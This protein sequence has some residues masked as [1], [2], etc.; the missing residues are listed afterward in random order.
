MIKPSPFIFS[1]CI[2]GE[3]WVWQHVHVWQWLPCSPARRSRPRYDLPSHTSHFFLVLYSSLCTFQCLGCSSNTNRTMFRTS[4]MVMEKMDMKFV[5]IWHFMHWIIIRNACWAAKQYI[6]MISEDH[7]TE[8][9]SNDAGNTALITGI[10]NILTNI[11]TQNCVVLHF[12]Q[13]HA[14]WGH[15]T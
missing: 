11:T 7:V 8:D 1:C 15:K 4:N 6:R 9:W 3:S 10:N 14:A 13:I 2:A 12:P 5:Q